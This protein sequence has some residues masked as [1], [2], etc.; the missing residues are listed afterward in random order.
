MLPN[1]NECWWDSIILDIVVCN[2]F[3]RNSELLFFFWLLSFAYNLCN[4][5]LTRFL[6]V[7]VLI[8]CIWQFLWVFIFSLLQI[9]QKINKSIMLTKKH[10]RFLHII[11]VFCGLFV[12]IC[13]LVF[14]RPFVKTVN[15]T[16]PLSPPSFQNPPFLLSLMSFPTFLL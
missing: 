7:C 15:A 14:W 12:S 5:L 1:F 3:G 6:F 13:I 16:P 4:V 9:I 8:A 10:F 11:S 2:W